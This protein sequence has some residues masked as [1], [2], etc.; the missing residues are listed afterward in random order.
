MGKYYYIAFTKDLDGNWSDEY[1]GYNKQEVKDDCECTDNKFK[2]FK[3]LDDQKT[4]QEFLHSKNEEL[5]NWI[6]ETEITFNMELNK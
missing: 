4:I 6:L 2:I 5:N 3:V 1:A